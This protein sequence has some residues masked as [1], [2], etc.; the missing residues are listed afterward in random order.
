MKIANVAVKSSIW[1][2]PVDLST[3]GPLS[4]AES[5][6]LMDL[7]N[8]R[9]HREVLPSHWRINHHGKE[10]L[11]PGRALQP[12]HGDGQTPALLARSMDSP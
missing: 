5:A 3:G 4:A 10:V 11:H 8:E 2:I 9:P 7:S 6:I 1:A 12:T